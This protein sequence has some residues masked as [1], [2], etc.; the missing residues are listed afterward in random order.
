MSDA[1]DDAGRGAAQGREVGDVPAALGA[2][3]EQGG[4]G[5]RAV[6]RIGEPRPIA[7]ILHDPSLD[8]DAV[9]AAGAAAALWLDRERLE[10]ELRARVAELRDSR[11]RLV[12]TADAERRRIERDLHDGAQQRIASLLLHLE[13]ERRA[14]GSGATADV[15]D[16]IAAGLAE[17]LA[18]LRALAAGILPPVLRQDG[19][20]AAVEELA[21]R[22]AVPVDV[23]AMPHRRLPD[24]VEAAAYFFVA[25]GLANVV[26]HARARRA[27]VRVFL[28]AGH[29]IV[30]VTD[31]GRG[32]ADERQGS[33][34]RGLADRVGA[35]GGRLICHSPSNGG[36]VLRAEIPCVS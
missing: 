22:T 26:K 7:A 16:N 30:E 4:G 23:E 20:A 12:A 31:E 2:P 17:S 29:V 33:G 24:G 32:G 14:L 9:R 36:T 13:L 10:A 5:D 11:A 8:P 1:S 28:D 3:V 21:A 34:L 25:E 35:L 15:L 18:E 19:L 6:T 27:A